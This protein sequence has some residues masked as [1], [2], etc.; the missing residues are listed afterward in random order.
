MT[1]RLRADNH[2]LHPYLTR[3]KIQ[4]TVA[5]T[6]NQTLSPGQPI[7]NLSQVI[8]TYPNIILTYLPDISHTYLNNSIVI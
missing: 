6:V 8:Q 7:L 4:N 3:T 2:M 5:M 1:G